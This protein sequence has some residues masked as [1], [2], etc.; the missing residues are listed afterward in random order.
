MKPFALAV[1]ALVLGSGCVVSSSSPPPPSCTSSV[2]TDWTFTYWGG[3]AFVQNGGCGG[4]G[5]GNV[6]VYLDGALVQRVACATGGLTITNVAQ[7]NHT[8]DVEGID[9]VTGAIALRDSFGVTATC[10]DQLIHAH[11]A[12]GWANLDYV[13]NATNNA[14]CNANFCYVWL[15]VHDNIANAIA[16]AYSSTSG[17]TTF[18]YPNDALFLLP[19]GSYSVDWMQLVYPTSPTTFA[20]LSYGNGCTP[21]PTFNIAAMQSQATFAY[22][23]AASLTCL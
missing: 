6:D 4:A 19:Q 5:I 9:A 14:Y 8:V 17:A 1:T 11:P 23:P 22:T 3:A 10:A 18:R 20:Q 15:Q 16:A 2:T 13:A 12:E 7:G 21:L